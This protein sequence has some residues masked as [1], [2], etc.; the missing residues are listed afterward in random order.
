MIAPAEMYTPP[1]R[2]ANLLL[3]DLTSFLS[4]FFSTEFIVDLSSA[5][6]SSNL[7]SNVAISADSADVGTGAL[8]TAVDAETLPGKRMNK[9]NNVVSD[10][11]IFLMVVLDDPSPKTGR[12]VFL[13]IKVVIALLVI[14]TSGREKLTYIPLPTWLN[15]KG[16]PRGHSRI[17]GFGVSL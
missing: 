13:L 12:C 2:F 5:L 8:V 3:I 9:S 1:P 17:M 6:T 15:A 11:C 4:A 16:Y 10:I 14:V 7:V